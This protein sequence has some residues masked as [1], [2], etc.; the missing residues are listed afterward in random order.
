MVDSRHPAT[1]VASSAPTLELNNGKE[2]ARFELTHDIHRLG[3]DAS[4]ADLFVEGDSWGVLSRRQA[5]LKR[6]GNQY[7]IFDGDGQT[8]SS[9]G[10]FVNS[11]LAPIS[12]SPIRQ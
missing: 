5:I 7:H 11:D 10:I 6:E 12:L 9:N 4:W 1:V 2:L 3:R 8:P